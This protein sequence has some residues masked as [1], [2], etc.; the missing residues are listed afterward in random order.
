MKEVDSEQNTALSWEKKREV[1][2]GR[3]LF[4]D[5]KS[6]L[7]FDDFDEDTV[8]SE[9]LMMTWLLDVTSKTVFLMSKETATKLLVISLSLVK[10]K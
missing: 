1:I 4:L 9:A 5:K 6:D 3:T 2:T 7:N 8:E 10:M